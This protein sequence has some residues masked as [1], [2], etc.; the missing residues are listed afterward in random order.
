MAKPLSENAKTVLKDLQENYGKE[1]LYTEV[2]E[3]TGLAPRSVNA[4]INALVKRGLAERTPMEITDGEGKT[5]TK[6]S[7][8]ATA[9][10]LDFDPDAEVE[11]EAAE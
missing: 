4:L 9:E 5:V 8:G 3:R 6:N 1:M 11:E 7:V 2:A 10:G